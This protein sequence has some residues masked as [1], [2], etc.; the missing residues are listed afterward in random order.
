MVRNLV[1][2]LSAVLLFCSAP[3]GA[4]QRDEGWRFELTPYIWF[5]GIS[6]DV[7]L[8]Q[9]NG[10]D[11]S[12]DFGD[13][14][15]A[16]KFAAMGTFE[17]RRDRWSLILDLFYVNLQE[18]FSS[19]NSIGVSGGDVRTQT[20]EVSAIGLYRVVENPSAFLDLGGGLRAWWIKTE[21]EANAGLLAGRSA[22][23][24]KNLV[25][26]VLA[27][28]IGMRLTERT[29]LT[30]YGDVGGFNINSTLSWQAIG[31][32]D[33]QITNDLVT[34]AGWRHIQIDT[35]NSGTSVDLALSGPFL[36]LTYRF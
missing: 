16:L 2:A 34:R 28:R 8:P 12:A 23:S 5:S 18:G 21:I 20:T 17:A 32:L 7:R 19:P 30:F 3:A 13:I 27:A 1:A 36:G 4:Q 33:W 29:A 11:F 10:E 25:N 15:S 26:G 35:Q 24:T 9:G 6:G 31:S 22:S 14:F